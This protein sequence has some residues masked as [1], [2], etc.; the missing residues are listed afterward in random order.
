M[1]LF[2]RRWLLSM[3]QRLRFGKKNTEEEQPRIT[4]N[5]RD[6]ADKEKISVFHLIFR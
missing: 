6:N 5:A 1:S 2:R 3:L 4:V